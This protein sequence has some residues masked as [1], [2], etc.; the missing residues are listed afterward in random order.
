METEIKELEQQ[1]RAK[2]SEL[3]QLNAGKELD[4]LQKAIEQNENEISECR[5]VL[6]ASQAG[7]AKN[8]SYVIEEILTRSRREMMQCLDDANLSSE[9]SADSLNASISGLENDLVRVEKDRMEVFGKLKVEEG[10]L[11][12]VER[13]LSELEQVLDQGMKEVKQEYAEYHF[14]SEDY[15]EILSEFQ[16][17]KQIVELLESVECSGR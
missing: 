8:G 7:V 4:L 16:D 9:L 3:E 11:T 13:Q 10:R 15:Y 6:T 14:Q 12:E 17:R 5:M 1:L 2:E